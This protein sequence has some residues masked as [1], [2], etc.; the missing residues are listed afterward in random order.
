M[1]CSG[2]CGSLNRSGTA[3]RASANRW[4]RE[5]QTLCDLAL[6][7]DHAKAAELQEALLPCVAATF[8]VKNP[9]PL[10]HMLGAGLRLPLVT[11]NELR[12]PGRSAA[13]AKIAKA[14][15]IESF[16][17]VAVPSRAPQA[18]AAG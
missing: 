4:P 10:H 6:A 12:E 13:L 11:V 17:L 16:P 1:S 2:S 8:C 14:E 3:A 18:L 7:G 9:I 5:F 15:A